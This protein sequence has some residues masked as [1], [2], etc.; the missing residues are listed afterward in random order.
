MSEPGPSR[1]PGSRRGERVPHPVLAIAAVVFT[2]VVLVGIIAAV[3][4]AAFVV[5]R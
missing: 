1:Q 3:I 4:V 2:G 5:E